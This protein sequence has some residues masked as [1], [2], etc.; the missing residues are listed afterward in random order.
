MDSLTYIAPFWQ[1]AEANGWLRCK[2]WAT[3]PEPRC[4]NGTPSAIVGLLGDG[5]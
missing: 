2:E 3:C 4:T 1:A 5:I